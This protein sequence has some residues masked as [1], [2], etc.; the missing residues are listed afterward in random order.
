MI[1][2][3]AKISKTKIED[4]NL[5]F[6]ELLTDLKYELCSFVNSPSFPYTVNDMMI[7]LNGATSGFYSHHLDPSINKNLQKTEFIEG[8]IVFLSEKCSLYDHTLVRTLVKAM[9]CEEAEKV[10]RN[11]TSEIDNSLLKELNLLDQYA[12]FIDRNLPYNENRKL[13]IKCENKDLNITLNDERL[14]RCKLCDMFKLPEHGFLL[15]DVTKGCIALIYEISQKVKDHMLHC[16]ITYE[17]I[18]PLLKVQKFV[19]TQVIIDDELELL[20][21][22]SDKVFM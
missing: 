2:V 21:M 17:E 19:I 11:F 4:L 12:N 20:K 5:K 10:L 14:I 22:S 8:I 1:N 16:T 7:K 3:R 9:N 6:G 15:A 13:T 18:K